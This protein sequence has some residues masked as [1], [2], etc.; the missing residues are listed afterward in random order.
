M[1]SA[2]ASAR[3]EEADV[4]VPD[5]GPHAHLRLGDADQRADFARVIHA[6][7]DHRDVGPRAQLEQRE[8][9]AD[10]V[11]Q[12]APVPKHRVLRRQE[13]RRELLR[14]RLARAAR[15]GD[16]L[17]ARSPSHLARAVLQRP[18][19]VRHLDQKRRRPCLSCLGQGRRRGHHRAGRSCG[20]R[21]G[22]E[23]VPVEPVAADRDEQ[24][25]RLQRPRVDRPAL[26][27]LRRDRPR[28]PARRSA[29]AISAALSDDRRPPVTSPASRCAGAPAPPARLRRR[30]TAASCRRS[31]GTFRA[32]CRRSAADRRAA[33]P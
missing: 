23:F 11:V 4:R 25:A 9:Q 21:G 12:V 2:I 22:D 15:D 8:R 3:L 29:A 26:D 10:V 24:V 6:Q 7:L 16:D 18:R 1:A 27:A 31:P 32:P 13:L 30:R 28:P 14:R 19:R 20:Q 33:R 17:R 5:V